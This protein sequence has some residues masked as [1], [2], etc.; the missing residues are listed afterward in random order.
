MLNNLKEQFG[1]IDIYLFDQLLKGTYDHCK[2]IID[3]GCGSGRN[4][5][6]FLRQGFDVYAIDRNEEA[7]AFTRQLSI[8]LAAKN[9]LNNFKVALAE[10]IPFPDAFFDLAI[11]SAVL[12]F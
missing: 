3:V 9:D 6:Y 1:D 4:I 11:C 10:D 5:L 7:I 12:H 2:T 8:A